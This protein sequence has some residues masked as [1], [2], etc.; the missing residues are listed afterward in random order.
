MMPSSS[1]NAPRRVIEIAAIAVLYYGAANLGLPLAWGNTNASP[2]WP[3]AGIALG[4]VLWLGYRVWPG[5]MLGACL[6]NV[7]AFLRSQAAD[8]G[9]IL[10]TSAI[11]GVGNTLEAV[12]GAWLLRRVAVSSG[13]FDRALDV[14]KFVAAT[15]VA[16]FVSASIGATTVSLAGLASPARYPTVWF[17]WWLGDVVGVL[18]VTPLL[19]TW[20]YRPP[21]LSRPR[22]ALEAAVLFGGLVLASQVG[23]G[24]WPLPQ[25]AHYPLGFLPIPFLVWAAVRFGPR[26]AA[27]AAAVTAGI[28]V[29]DTMY[30]YG[31]FVGTTVQGSLLFL[32]AFLG[33]LAATIL[34]MAAVV[35]ERQAAQ[36]TLGR[37][38]DELELRVTERTQEL[39]RLTETLRADITER[40]RV[41]EALGQSEASFRLL[42]A[43]HPQP[44]WVYD[45]ETLHFLEVNEAAVAHY[46]YSRDEFLHMRITDIRPPEDVPRLL[47]NLAG[48]RP[49]LQRSD[50]WR[51]RRRDGRIIDVEIT[52]HTLEF[53]GRRAA[54]VVAADITERRQGEEALRA[55]EAQLRQA[56]KMEAVGRLAGGIAHDFNNLLTV[57]IGRATITL[58]SLNPQG[59]LQHNVELIKK[60]A[61][62]AAALTQQLLAF[63]RKQV[64]QPKLLDLHAVVEQIAPMLSRLIGEDVELT[65]RSQPGLWRV[66]AD[67]GQLEQV[68]LNLVV[69]A[70]DA[71]PRGG[72]VSIE[73]ADIE[74]S[75]AYTHL[76]DAVP[77]GSYVMLKVADTGM[78]MDAE[79]QA[80]IFEP[81]FTT[82]DP[83]KGTGL[84]LSTV[85]GIVSQHDGT[86]RVYSAP[87]QGTTFKIYLP[88]AE[89][90]AEAVVTVAP[91]AD[92]TGG[93]E[94]VLLVEDDDEVRRL[95]REVLIANG[96]K[97]LD[98]ADPATAVQLSTQQAAAAQLLITDVVMPG[99]SGRQL[100]ERIRIRRPEI[101]VLYVSGYPAEALGR[102]GV[103]DQGIALLAKPFSPKDLARK[104]REVLDSPLKSQ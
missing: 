8:P 13:L 71:M 68:I 2:V 79:T 78:G 32:Q 94:M 101:R 48:S 66:R 57:I 35:A 87:G 34:A 17:T 91:A 84:G 67:Q 27:T 104:V 12:G 33:V 98:A 81:F 93:T 18:V 16:C 70:R 92:G 52:S 20:C 22:Q 47:E 5:V 95:S 37:A 58:E 88:K 1:P 30:G 51:H 39:L 73:T 36:A 54:L 19:L 62:R 75:A 64:L 90:T 63:S 21:R 65:I 28:A 25:D 61:D 76:P 50:Q 4:A 72:R 60:T 3:S 74:L 15:L 10:A 96:Y 7:E 38:R 9:T 45:L 103:V 43:D 23:F 89:E 85:Y 41:A 55:S 24:G 26:E 97:V 31:P 86:I 100:A 99:M 40:T 82:K 83:G 29:W 56:Q 69:N 42:F 53:T 80:R 77:A 49:D 6:A 14:F 59:A 46:G 11:I 44:M 102:H